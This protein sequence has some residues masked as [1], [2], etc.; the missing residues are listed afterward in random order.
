MKMNRYFIKM[1]SLSLIT[2]STNVVAMEGKRKQPDTKTVTNQQPAKKSK[3]ASGFDIEDLEKEIEELQGTTEFSAIAE[4]AN[5]NEATA[6]FLTA[7]RLGKLALIRALLNDDVRSKLNNGDGYDL[8]ALLAKTSQYSEIIRD[9][10]IE[11][12][13][14]G[15]TALHMAAEG[16]H[17]EIIEELLKSPFA[18]ELSKP[19]GA[20]ETILHMLVRSEGASAIRRL[21]ELELSD[22]VKSNLVSRDEDG[23]NA[24]K[25]AAEFDNIEEFE[26]LITSSLSE[27]LVK[28]NDDGVTALHIAA[29]NNSRN[30]IQ[31]LLRSKYIN[32]LIKADKEGK[33]PI[34]YAAINNHLEAAMDILSIYPAI[35]YQEPK[36]FDEQI[37]MYQFLSPICL[38]L[39]VANL[40]VKFV[41]S[42]LLS[43]QYIWGDMQQ[44]FLRKIWHNKPNINRHALDKFISELSL[45]NDALKNKFNKRHALSTMYKYSY[46][47]DSSI[48][49]KESSWE[50]RSIKTIDEIIAILNEPRMGFN[51][52]SLCVATM[53]DFLLNYGVCGKNN[54]YFPHTLARVAES[55]GS[56]EPGSV[57]YY[58]EDSPEWRQGVANSA[59]LGSET[60]KGFLQRCYNICYN[61]YNEEK[62]N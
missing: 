8:K 62:I 58:L 47:K 40:D 39:G 3:H 42:I 24:L 28:P 35:A 45:L 52:R 16:D 6:I 20:G 31:F 48:P 34:H 30:V 36:I 9:N 15:S 11:G 21:T 61:K 50:M 5:N 57:N 51:L 10:T 7:A 14:E 60:P 1:I 46:S 32:G 27:D 33:T 56:D 38:S 37:N 44:Q 22:A 17:V 25:L 29:L 18:E 59:R 23:Y 19:D 55:L 54:R 49:D 41:K 2:L 13:A 12:H 4:G 43:T 53:K 26:V